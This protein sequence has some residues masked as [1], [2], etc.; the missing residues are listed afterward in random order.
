MFHENKP[1]TKN[2]RLGE[3]NILG[4]G[5]EK[6]EICMMMAVNGWSAEGGIQKKTP[7]KGGG[8]E[9]KRCMI[10]R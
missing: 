7:K 8:G 10:K 1:H 4:C 3:S 6:F 5:L 9:A 2:R